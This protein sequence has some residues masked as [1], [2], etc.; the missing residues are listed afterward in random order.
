MMKRAGSIGFIAM[1][2]VVYTWAEWQFFT[3]PVPGGND[4]LTHYGAWEA[5]LKHGLNPYSD[6]AAVY[7]QTLIYGR[8]AQGSEDQNRLAY[9][10]YSIIL[11]GP[12]V[13]IEDYALARA[14]YMTLLQ[15]ALFVG[16][17]WSLR[18]VNWR[19][20]VWLTAIVLAWSLLFYPEARGVILGQFAIFGFFSL[21][22]TLYLLRR[23]RDDVAGALLVLS[24]IKPT[25]VFLV[26]PFL[27]M[28]AITRRRWQ[29]IM[30]FVATLALVLLISWLMLPSWL[31][32]WVYRMTRYSDYTVGQSPVWL[33]THQMLPTL[34][35]TGE[36]IVDV[37]LISV[38]L[39]TWW[40]ALRS[41]D[42]D[43]FHWSL[44]V[45]LVVSN[46]IVSRSA[47]TNYV[48]LLLPILW[49]FAVFDRRRWGRLAV[50]IGMLVSFIGLWWLHAATVVGNQEQPIMFM[51]LPLALGLMLVAAAPRH[52]GQRSKASRDAVNL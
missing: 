20:A 52:I 31:N 37:V 34:S 27:F 30:G 38:M 36:A 45:T 10:F 11:H 19:P 28:W 39:G 48:M 22:G 42:G 41:T 46:L 35:D 17:I 18:V 33:L 1:L 3:R 47:T 49:L 29:F 26:I 43:R 15:V 51:P 14:I 44:G 7:V 6:E 4:F 25:L 23:R 40:L 2:L 50:V 13:L 9:P 16:V 24:T 21:A 12:F 5:Y 8:P 32:D